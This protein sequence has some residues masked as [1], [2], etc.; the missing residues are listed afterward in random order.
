[1][2]VRPSLTSVC[3]P[4]EIVISDLLRTKMMIISKKKRRGEDEEMTNLVHLIEQCD[5]IN[6]SIVLHPKLT[7]HMLL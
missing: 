4:K 3:Q 6:L 5:D 2:N 1:M 7:G